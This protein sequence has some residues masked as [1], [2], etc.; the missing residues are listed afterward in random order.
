[1]QEPPTGVTLTST[2][3]PDGSQSGTV[4]GLLGAVDPDV[5][6]TFAFALVAG[7][8]DTDNA[9]FSIVGDELRTGFVADKGTKETY[10]VRL[11]A[12][13]QGGAGT[14]VA[15]AFTITVVSP[16]G[17]YRGLGG[18]VRPVVEVA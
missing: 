14:P 16:G 5:G 15:Q 18:V 13:D 1:M 6:E 4:V 11:Q 3:V 2:T 9:S 8:G 7:T 12:T 17:D 10:G